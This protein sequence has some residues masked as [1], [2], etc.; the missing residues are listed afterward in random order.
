MDLEIAIFPGGNVKNILL[1]D[2]NGYV[3]DALALTINMACG[4]CAILKAKDGNEATNILRRTPVDL[5]LTDI[6]MPVMDGFG[7]IG[8]RNEHWPEVPL[9]AMPGDPSPETTRKLS[10][11]GITECLEKPFSYEAVTSLVLKKLAEP[12]HLHDQRPVAAH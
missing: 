8:Q 3:I 4:D 6:N 1:V 12:Q 2:D 11:L 7:L 9:L 5:I 10:S